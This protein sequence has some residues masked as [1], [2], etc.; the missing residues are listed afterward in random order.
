M[1][2]GLRGRGLAGR[3]SQGEGIPWEGSECGGRGQGRKENFPSLWKRGAR[4]GGARVC[5]DHGL[6]VWRGHESGDLAPDSKPWPCWRFEDRACSR[7][8]C[9]C[10]SE[11]KIST[12]E[13]TLT[14]ETTEPISQ[15]GKGT[16]LQKK[17]RECPWLLGPHSC[18]CGRHRAVSSEEDGLSPH[19]ATWPGSGHGTLLLLPCGPE[20]PEHR[21]PGVSPPSVSRPPEKH[22]D[23]LRPTFRHEQPC[24]GKASSTRVPAVRFRV[25]LPAPAES[26]WDAEGARWVSASPGA[27]RGRIRAH[28]V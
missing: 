18:R 16:R 28:C 25:L 1:R 14:Q 12:H 2:W 26:P 19:R 4:R 13:A 21:V 3:G 23:G 7:A 24:P 6:G 22:R 11:H 17:P 27:P 15:W 20:T 9:S 5:V 8:V 10:I